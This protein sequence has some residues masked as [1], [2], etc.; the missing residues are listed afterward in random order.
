MPARPYMT[1]VDSAKN[2]MAVV[3]SSVLARTGYGEHCDGEA[4][5]NIKMGRTINTRCLLPESN[6][7][8]IWCHFFKEP[9]FYKPHLFAWLK[10]SIFLL[11]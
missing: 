3:D 2:G 9:S 11:N 1:V 10:T 8:P 6:I 7:G 4:S 5:N